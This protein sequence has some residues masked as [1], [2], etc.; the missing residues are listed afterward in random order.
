MG[1]DYAYDEEV[2]AVLPIVIR[3]SKRHPI[4]PDAMLTPCTRRNSSPISSSR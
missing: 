4:P 1:S 2:C 3:L